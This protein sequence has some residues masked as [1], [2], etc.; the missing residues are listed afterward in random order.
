MAEASL[1][2]PSRP[3]TEGVVQRRVGKY[4]AF[5]LKGPIKV[6][7]LKIDL[8]KRMT[9]YPVTF[10]RQQIYAVILKYIG[11]RIQEDL[12]SVD[13]TRL[14]SHLIIQALVDCVL[15]NKLIAVKLY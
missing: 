12:T 13:P 15:D 11:P 2:A 6:S 8:T 9:S 4:R 14:L 3:R 10:E 5:R 7:P 1:A